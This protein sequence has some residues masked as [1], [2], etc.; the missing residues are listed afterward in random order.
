MP[1]FEAV[2]WFENL[3]TLPFQFSECLFGVPA[4]STNPNAIAPLVHFHSCLHRHH[5]LFTAAFEVDG[6]ME[7]DAVELKPLAAG[8]YISSTEAGGA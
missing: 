7:A 3:A 4:A 1:R 5:P 8:L 6:R 2:A